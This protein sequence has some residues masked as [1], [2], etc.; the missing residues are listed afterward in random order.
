MRFIGLHIAEHLLKENYRV[1]ILVKL[2]TGHQINID[3]LPFDFHEQ[4]IT[5]PKALDVIKS[6]DPDY[7]IL[8]AAQMS[9][10]ESV[11]VFQMMKT[12]I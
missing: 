7:I 6:I 3:G 11:S 9:I 1:A 8:L 5:K 12:S 10:A 4:D 2:T